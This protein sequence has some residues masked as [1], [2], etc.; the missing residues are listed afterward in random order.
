V[1]A[2]LA[3][4]QLGFG[5]AFLVG[6]AFPAWLGWLSIVIGVVALLGPLAFLALMATGVWV[7]IVSAMIYPRL[8]AGSEAAI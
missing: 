6:K 4:M 7:L 8:A 3:A 1:A 5:V 2:G